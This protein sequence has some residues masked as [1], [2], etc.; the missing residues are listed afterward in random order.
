[1]GTALVSVPQAGKAALLLEHNAF[2]GCCFYLS[3]CRQTVPRAQA[4]LCSSIHPLPELFIHSFFFPLIFPSVFP[5][6]VSDEFLFL[7]QLSTAGINAVGT[8][9]Q[10]RRAAG[11][12]SSRNK[13]RKGK[14]PA[15]RIRRGNSGHLGSFSQ[16]TR[17]QHLCSPGR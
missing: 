8:R 13:N 17:S 7:Q 16:Q 1:M 3:Q 15:V 14:Y 9:L 5:L 10:P 4:L 2:V 12:T 11:V 6:L